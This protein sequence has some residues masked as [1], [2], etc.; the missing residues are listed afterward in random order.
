MGAPSDDDL[1]DDSHNEPPYRRL[2]SPPEGWTADDLDRLPDLPSHTELLDGSLVFRTPQT[3][4][5]A[6]CLR[7]LEYGL[8]ARAPDH[9]DVVRE[10]TVKLDERNRPEPDLMVLPVAAHTGPDQ[11]CYY[12]RDVLLAVEVTSPDSRER[13]HEVKPRK[14]AAAGIPHFWLVEQDESTDKGLP[15]VH[16]QALDLAAQTYAFT[17]TFH[18]CLKVT[19]PFAIEIDLTAIHRR[20]RTAPEPEQ[21]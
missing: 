4:F 3:R 8:L 21:G 17:G 1:D 13:D 11:T 2:A 9:L 5:H 12:S 16:T 14:Y 15:V 19:V 18:D 6:R 7:L 10:M 20:P